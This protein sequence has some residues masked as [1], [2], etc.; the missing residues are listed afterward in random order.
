MAPGAAERSV[1]VARMGMSPRDVAQ[2]F[3]KC[4]DAPIDSV[5][6]AIANGIS[7][8]GSEVVMDYTAGRVVGYE[9]E[10][11]LTFAPARATSK[12]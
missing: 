9:P 1:S 12:L 4:V 7:N 2:L 6:F 5:P 10:D 11:G 8:H 3:R